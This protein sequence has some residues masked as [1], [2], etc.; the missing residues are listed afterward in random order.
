VLCVV[1]ADPHLTQVHCL[2]HCHSEGQM[3]K[4][5]FLV[6]PHLPL[7][8]SVNTICIQIYIIIKPCIF[9]MVKTMHIFMGYEPRISYLGATALNYS[10]PPYQSCI[11]SLYNHFIFVMRENAPSTHHQRNQPSLLHLLTNLTNFCT[12]F[13]RHYSH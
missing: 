5:Q 8:N 2:T 12:A 1:E 7:S 11:L 6:L 13:S 3:S 4:R 9:L 10:Q